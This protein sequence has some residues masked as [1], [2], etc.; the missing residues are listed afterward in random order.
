MRVQRTITTIEDMELDIEGITLLSVEEAKALPVEIR[1]YTN[2]NWWLRS[3]GDD[4][5]ASLVIGPVGGVYSIGYLVSWQ[6][7]VRPALRVNL[8]SSDLQIGDKLTIFN[9]SWTVISKKLIFCDDIV[10]RSPFR[11]DW[12][13]SD[14]NDYEASDIK[15]WLEDWYADQVAQAESEDKEWQ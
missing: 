4:R 13:A 1:K 11:K 15:K 14:S 8:E 2:N 10:G 7:G 3:S 9:R 12:D 5:K 6:R